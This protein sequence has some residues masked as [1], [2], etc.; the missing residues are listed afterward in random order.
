[1]QPLKE[2]A[3]KGIKEYG[4][5]LKADEAITALKEYGTAMMADY[6]ICWGLPSIILVMSK[7]TGQRS[8]ENGGEFIRE[9]ILPRW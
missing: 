9:Q 3:F 1:M 6:A 7:S 5:K 2:K 8:I 4:K